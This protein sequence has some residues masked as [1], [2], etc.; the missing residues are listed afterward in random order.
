M[1][2]APLPLNENERLNAL[3]RYRILDTPPEPHFDHLVQL[4]SHLCGTPMSLITLVDKERV[5]FKANLGF[6]ASEVSR[7][8]SFCSHTVLDTSPL[9]INDTNDDPRFV[10]HPLVSG[11]PKIRFYAGVPLLTPDG[12]NLGSLC[13]IDQQPRELNDFQAFALSSLAEQA[14]QLLEQRHFSLQKQAQ[15]QV[16][17]QQ[18][19]Q[20]Q[21]AQLLNQRLLKLLDQELQEPLD[22]LLGL[23]Q[24]PEHWGA[25]GRTVP[26]DWAAPM[27]HKLEDLAQVMRQLRAWQQL[28]TGEQR[29]ET[30]ALPLAELL[31][32]LARRLQPLADSNSSEIQIRVDPELRVQAPLEPLRLI[33]GSLMHNALKRSDYGQISFEAELT[34]SEC[35]LLVR[36]SGPGIP[37]WLQDVLGN[38]IPD[39]L[40]AGFLGEHG[41]GLALLVSSRYAQALGGRLEASQT[42]LGSLVRLVLPQT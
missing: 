37:A 35:V 29:W 17:E 31:Q 7:Q 26:T 39:P 15:M 32:A 38:Q 19:Q 22:D 30:T 5:W 6:E 14:M 33:L 2:I 9:V 8:L 34:E 16:I 20:L 12:F 41:L 23:I 27:H 36:D 24:S 18:R 21:D 13:V 28:Q 42:S 3:A 11:D 10:A 40:N 1:H 4:A 25:S